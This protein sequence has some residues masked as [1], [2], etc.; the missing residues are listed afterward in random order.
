MD[1]PT[2]AVLQFPGVNCEYETARILR[3]C[4]FSASLFRWNEDPARLAEF[5]GFVLPGG[6]SY[7]DRV[8]AG[9]VA[10]RD[11]I[12]GALAR[13]ADGGKPVLGICNGAQVLVES[14][15]VPGPA[16]A[17]G[18]VALA[19]NRMPDRSGYYCRWVHLRVNKAGRETAF[20]SRFED[21]AVV[22]MPM[23]H[24]EGRFTARDESIF[25]GFVDSGQVALTYCSPDGGAPREFPEN[26]NGAAANAAALTNEAGNVMAIMPHPE[27]G[28]WL[29][30]VPLNLPGE[31]GGR[32]RAAFRNRSE[33]DSAGPG[34]RLFLSMHDYIRW[35]RERESSPAG[36]GASR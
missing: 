7:Q 9:A 6:F 11:P 14:G 32:R 26:P 35:R 5:E 2:I 30:Q 20:T 8:R 1:T 3:E 16:H 34:R 24:G 29:R 10:A 23:A 15:L 19:P 27:R 17:G 4:G 21:G 25:E 33:L 31:W 28:G 22:P 13:E 36:T 18:S 12:V